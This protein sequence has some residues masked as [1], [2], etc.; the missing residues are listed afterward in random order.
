MP[1]PLPARSAACALLVALAGL[2]CG[3]GDTRR[4]ELALREKSVDDGGFLLLS[5]RDTMATEHYSRSSGHLRGRLVHGD[6][7]RID[8]DATLAADESIV[9][10]ELSLWRP[11]S[12]LDSRPAQHSVTELRGPARDSLA[13]T[14]REQGPERKFAA[15]VPA[16]AQPY[17][18]PSVALAQQVLRHARRHPGDTASIPI[19]VLNGAAL[20]QRVR[21]RWLPGD[22]ADVSIAG[23]HVRVGFDADGR[24]RDGSDP[25]LGMTLRRLDR[26]K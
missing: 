8:Y 2:A 4:P 22:S 11:G 26:E 19:V 21:V 5:E 13:R 25:A 24:V 6:G 3:R 15:I 1:L 20:P 17:L 9:R 14:D 10:L 18:I 12:P 16:G 7:T 23:N